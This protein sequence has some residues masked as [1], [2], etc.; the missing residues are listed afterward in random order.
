MKLRL[1]QEAEDDKTKKDTI[2]GSINHHPFAGAVGIS[3]Y[4]GSVWIYS[5]VQT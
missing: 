5:D 2:S 1:K 3:Q 4:P